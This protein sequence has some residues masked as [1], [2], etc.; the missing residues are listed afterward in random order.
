MVASHTQQQDTE[1][2]VR[3]IVDNGTTKRLTDRA[4]QGA[5]QI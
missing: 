3:P 5:C 1:A 4:G 2:I